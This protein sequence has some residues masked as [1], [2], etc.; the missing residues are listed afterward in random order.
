MRRLALIAAALPLAACGAQGPDPRVTLELDAPRDPATVR[1]ETV[2]VRGTVSPPGARVL[3]AGKPAEREG[4]SFSATV[5]LRPGGNV[6]DVTATAAGAR[7]DV[8]AVRVMRDIRVEIPALAGEDSDTAQERLEALGLE[9]APERGGGFLDRF[10]LGA[11]KVC[12]TSPSKG[13]LVQPHS[14]VIVVI[15]RKC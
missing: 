9:P 8:G 3:V 1:A 13:T 2:E 11:L 6:I 7:P 14:R 15:A 5:A 10:V 12:E 4:G